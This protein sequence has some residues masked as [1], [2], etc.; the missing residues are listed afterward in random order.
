MVPV[1]R[2]GICVA[3]EPIP[4]DTGSSRIGSGFVRFLSRDP[5]A[6]LTFSLTHVGSDV[7]WVRLAGHGVIRL[8]ATLGDT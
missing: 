7:S 2:V 6:T 3:C 8:E 5:V 1:E 4:Q